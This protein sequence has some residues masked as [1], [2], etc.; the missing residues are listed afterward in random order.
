MRQK[1]EPITPEGADRERTDKDYWNKVLASHGLS[2]ARAYRPNKIR[3]I[4]DSVDIDKF[5]SQDDEL[6][7]ANGEARVSKKAW[8]KPRSATRNPEDLD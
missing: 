4:G 5:M 2:L 1:R 8:L 7:G 3:Y 6:D